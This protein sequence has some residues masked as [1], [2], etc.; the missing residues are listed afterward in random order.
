LWLAPVAAL[1]PAVLA[2][3]PFGAGLGTPPRSA[4]VSGPRGVCDRR[5]PVVWETRAEHKPGRCAMSSRPPA[6][7]GTSARSGL[8][9][10]CDR[11]DR[12]WGNSAPLTTLPT[13][14]SDRA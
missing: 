3:R 7:T 14:P 8:K 12:H 1:V 9:F 11:S 10:H 13:G 5:S 4:R 2:G 6:E